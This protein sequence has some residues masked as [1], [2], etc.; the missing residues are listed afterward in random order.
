MHELLQKLDGEG[1][2]LKKSSS[3]RTK[4]KELETILNTTHS[5]KTFAEVDE[6]KQKFQEENIKRIKAATFQVEI[7]SQEEEQQD[8]KEVDNIPDL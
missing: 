7:N 5:I 8:C 6:S 3:G 2:P 1:E 4:K